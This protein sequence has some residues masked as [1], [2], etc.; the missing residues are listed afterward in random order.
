MF[1][2]TLATDL[3]SEASHIALLTCNLTVVLR[4]KSVC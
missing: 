1:P 2:A 3:S 4:K